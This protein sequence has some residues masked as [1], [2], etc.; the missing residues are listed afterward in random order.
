MLD[1]MWLES[2]LG[3]IDRAGQMADNF[4]WNLSWSKIDGQWIVRSGEKPILKT[5][6]EETLQAFFYGMGLAY[7]VFSPEDV[8]VFRDKYD[9]E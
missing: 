4:Y 7:S 9:Y 2:H 3:D 8:E 6:S 1:M 5:D